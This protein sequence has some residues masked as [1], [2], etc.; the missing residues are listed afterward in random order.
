MKKG[1]R[2][3]YV[4][5]DA[6]SVRHTKAIAPATS[7]RFFKHTIRLS[8]QHTSATT[9]ASTTGNKNH[10]QNCYISVTH[11]DGRRAGCRASHVALDVALVFA[12]VYGQSRDFRV[13]RRV[14]NCARSPVHIGVFCTLACGDCSVSLARGRI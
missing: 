5:K 12:L 11:R 6:S 2:L 7:R 1:N 14:H 3:V 9:Y 4:L 10:L 13:P 8:P